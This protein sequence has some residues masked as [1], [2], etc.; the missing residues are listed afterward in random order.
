MQ[1]ILYERKNFHPK[2]VIIIPKFGIR[3]W[4][5]TSSGGLYFKIKSHCL[6]DVYL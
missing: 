6:S 4:S 2:R 1:P 5:I 3:S